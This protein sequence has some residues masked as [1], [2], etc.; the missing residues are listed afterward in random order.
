MK[1]LALIIFL[2]CASVYANPLQIVPVLREPAR[3]E[4]RLK[5]QIQAALGSML[6][7]INEANCDIDLANEAKAHGY[8]DDWADHLD[9]AG[10]YLR[11]AARYYYRALKLQTRLDKLR[12]KLG[13]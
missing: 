13:R 5:D 3:V 6:W 12:L 8:W 2:F 1:R 9:A 10:F 7:Y 11:R 4:V